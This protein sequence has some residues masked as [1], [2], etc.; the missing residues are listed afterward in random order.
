MV[1]K[2]PAWAEK[3][4]ATPTHRGWE[5]N[6]ELIKAAKHSQEQLDSYWGTDGKLVKAAKVEEE[7]VGDSEP[8]GAVPQMT[9][10]A[11]VEE[12]LVVDLSKMTKAQ[13]I[14]YAAEA[15]IEV[16]PKATKAVIMDTIN[17]A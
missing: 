9:V 14:E 10:E 12:V 5:V 11:T 16:D 7:P 4:G 15:G 6:G 8:V 1:I 17:G 13:L 2:A 3:M